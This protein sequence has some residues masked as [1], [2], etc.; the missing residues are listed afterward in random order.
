MVLNIYKFHRN[1]LNGSCHTGMVFLQMSHQVTSEVTLLWGRI[2]TLVTLDRF[3]SCMSYQVSRKASLHW[4]LF[5]VSLAGQ[6]N[7]V[8]RHSETRFNYWT[9]I[10]GRDLTISQELAAEP[11]YE[12]TASLSVIWNSLPEYITIDHR[13]RTHVSSD[14]SSSRN[15]PDTRSGYGSGTKICYFIPVRSGRK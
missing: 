13:L 12:R 5:K 4:S 1:G 7:L 8:D 14:S 9:S 10:R 15:G 11:I 2:I 3:F 6:L